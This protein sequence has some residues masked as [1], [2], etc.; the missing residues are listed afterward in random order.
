MDFL[1]LATIGSIS[2]KKELDPRWPGHICT[3]WD[4]ERPELMGIRGRQFPTDLQKPNARKG[5]H[6]FFYQTRLRLSDPSSSRSRSQARSHVK[7][8]VAPWWPFLSM[9]TAL[10]DDGPYDLAL[11]VCDGACSECTGVAPQVLRGLHLLAQ[12]ARGIAIWL[13]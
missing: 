3:G 11:R 12:A 13:K 4:G 7:S 2:F 1:V 9:A 5:S 6:D 10:V 8:C